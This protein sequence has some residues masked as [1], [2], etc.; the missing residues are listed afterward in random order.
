VLP[1][2]LLHVLLREHLSAPFPSSIE[3]GEDYGFVDAVMID[4]DI[5]GWVLTA[6][7]AG[8]LAPDQRAKLAKARD[9]LRGSLTVI[10]EEARPYYERLV[11]MA[12]LALIEEA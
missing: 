7:R 2:E 12:T 1:V 11:E 9:D 5:Y 8:R 10:P 4:A 3:K 6:A